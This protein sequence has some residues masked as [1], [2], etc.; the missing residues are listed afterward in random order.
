MMNANMRWPTSPERCPASDSGFARSGSNAGSACASSRE[1]SNSLRARSRRSRRARCGHRCARSTHW[2]AEFGLSVDEVF[3]EQGPLS[4]IRTLSGRRRAGARGAARGGQT[5]HRLELRC[6]LG[7]SDVLRR[8]GR[9]VRRGDIRT[10]RVRAAIP[11]RLAATVT[12]SDTSSGGHC[13][14]PSAPTGSFSRPGDS[15]TFRR[16]RPTGSSTTARSKCERYGSSAAGAVPTSA[17]KTTGRG[18]T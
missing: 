5:G 14:L 6:R 11:A 16:P 13:A 3:T 15:I 10:W 12:S 1:G 7:A 18:T 9:R 4:S 17:R 2:S 8:R